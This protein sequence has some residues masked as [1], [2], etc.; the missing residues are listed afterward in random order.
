[1]IKFEGDFEVLEKEII[2]QIVNEL[3]EINEDMAVVNDV[4]FKFSQVGKDIIV[5]KIDKLV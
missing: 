1:M 3:G 5:K 4:T 2:K